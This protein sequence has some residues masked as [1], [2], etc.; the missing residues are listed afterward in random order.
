M[1]DIIN[2][3]S[4]QFYIK[5]Y[6][7]TNS[8]KSRIVESI[9]KLDY[10]IRNAKFLKISNIF[11]KNAIIVVECDLVDKVKVNT[12]IG[13]SNASSVFPSK[14]AY[15]GYGGISG[16]D[17]MVKI[18]DSKSLINEFT[19]SVRNLRVGSF[20]YRNDIENAFVKI[21]IYYE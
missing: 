21:E 15:V 10:P 13:E 16:N 1:N 17:D 6:G 11:T 12:N 19:I 3:N 18:D 7:V 4:T 8:S 20:F 14:I 9:V 2:M 5:L